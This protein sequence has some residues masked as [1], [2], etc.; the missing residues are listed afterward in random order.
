A[1]QAR[2]DTVS[3]TAPWVAA[4]EGDIPVD[5]V[6]N[7]A[8]VA[9]GLA[10]YTWEASDPIHLS[11]TS[12]A[13][14]ANTRRLCRDRWCGVD[15]DDE[16]ELS[17]QIVYFISFTNYSLYTSFQAARCFYIHSSESY[18]GSINPEFG[19]D[20]LDEAISP[21]EFWNALRD[22]LLASV[23][24]F[25]K[26][27]PGFFSYSDF[28]VLTAGEAAHRPEFLDSLRSVAK[29]IPQLRVDHGVA[30]PPEVELVISDDPTFAAAHGA[31]F[32]FR[33]MTDRSYCDVLD[34]ISQYDMIRDGHSEL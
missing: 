25:T 22:Q 6:V 10:P 15:I 1:L 29:S 13:L 33:M 20:R 12:A 18:L 24:E 31:A 4:W 21:E 34:I 9:A 8:L 19:L 32:W 5:S 16:S 27:P 23:V 11:E 17:P 28:I 7:D 14:A 26:R 2:I 3:V 30:R